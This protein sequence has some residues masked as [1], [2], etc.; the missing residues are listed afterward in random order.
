[1]I[2]ISKVSHAGQALGYYAEKDDYYREGGAAPAHF[3]G[4]GAAALGL[5]GPLVRENSDAFAALL[6]GR[7]DGARVSDPDHEGDVRVRGQ[8]VGQADRHTPGW[9]VTF[10]A[11]KSASIAALAAGDDRLVAAHDR[12]VQAALAHLEQHAIVTRQRDEDGGYVWRHG[13]GMVAAVFRHTTS[14]NADPQLHSHVVVANVTRDP[15]TGAWRSL[16]SREIYA[17]QAEANAIY[18]NT[19]ARGAR[20]AGY[21]VDWSVNAQDHPSFELREVPA[22]LRE[23]WSSRTAEIDAA[24]AARGLTRE[25]ASAEEKQV[26]TLATRAPKS[27]EDRA[28][29]AAE[30]RA[31]ARAQGFG[32]EQRPQ[33]READPAARSAAADAAVARAVEHLAERDARFSVRDLLH[34]ARLASQG[35][36]GEKELQAAI[37]RAKESGELQSRRT[38][39]R[40]AGGQ[41]DWREGFTTREGL[42]TERAMLGHAAALQR[43]TVRIGESP[44]LARAAEREATITRVI[45]GREQATG[46]AFSS[47]QRAATAQLLERGSGLQILHGHAGTA[48]TTTVLATVAEVA[49]AGGWDVRAMAPT[50]SAAQTLG[51]ALGI[52]DETVSAA[53][54][55][56]PA[57]R[58]PGATPQRAMWI[59]DEAG[60]VAARD[61]EKLLARAEAEQAHVVLVGD[62][63]QI[64]SVGAGAAFTQL[65]E[66]LGSENLTEIVRQR[67]A[68]LR[69]AVYDA[70][71][72]KTTEAMQRITVH[73]I[74]VKAPRGKGEE[75]EQ[76]KRPSA[77]ELAIE[78]IVE[79]YSSN[80][81][82]GRDTLVIA[83]SRA[84]R[85]ELNDAIGVRLAREGRLGPARSVETLESKQ[86]TAAQRRDAAR[87]HPGDRI[88]WLQAEKDGPRKGEVTAVVARQGH[89]ITVEREDGTR[90][91][92]DPRQV[93]RIEVHNARTLKVG[94][95]ARMVTRAP[96][97]GEREDGSRQRLPNGTSLTVTG[98][99]ATHL[100]VRTAQGE[101]LRIATP[102]ALRIDA[103]YVM[104]ADAAQG[105]TCDTAIA[106]IR[107]T[108]QNLASA[109]RFYV[110]LSRA[111]L[112]VELVT[113]DAK[114]L[115]KRLEQNRGGN[116]TAL[117][118]TSTRDALARAAERS[119]EHTIGRAAESKQEQARPAPSPSRE[120]EWGAAMGR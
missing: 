33:G 80:T 77:R 87:Y 66:Q 63:K 30:W 28:A 23:A 35:K 45:A 113:D 79:A 21:S 97:Q 109:D 56:K 18:V 20:E 120:R 49:I 91:A 116:E 101:A 51:A 102:R 112:G 57:E 95:G 6:E 106:W 22:E 24:L 53:L 39:G 108:Q 78:R 74:K 119:S 105:K 31:T 3:F 38:W 55:A 65:R 84:D 114:L 81:A 90:Y 99:D 69:Q 118:P 62:T 89:R 47:E 42:R 16:D 8:Q 2:T 75:G 29:L 54:L 26:A 117:T 25:T 32:P 52:R 100:R 48:K 64:G 86:W 4:E 73:E 59:V 1:M 15:E 9:D 41:R 7:V 43:E 92:F 50:S 11:P 93:A 94:A 85:N 27:V 58:E 10:S 107:S 88:E 104:T 46:H 72:G 14:R 17:V 71:S 13:E 111:R 96:M 83:L 36:A 40:A 98:H 103:G 60:M 5:H 61:M 34:Q 115:A 44:A 110:A 76:E 67:D 82:A 12:A 19:L 68:G 70:L 37:A